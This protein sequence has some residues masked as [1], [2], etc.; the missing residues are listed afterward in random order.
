MTA[1]TT[2]I[3]NQSI[4]D[5]P[6]SG[7]FKAVLL[8]ILCQFGHRLPFSMRAVPRQQANDFVVKGNDVRGNYIGLRFSGNSDGNSFTE[9]RFTQN[10]HPIDVDGAGEN[11]RWAVGGVGNFWSGQEMF[12]LNG[13]GINDLPHQELDLFGPLRRDFP[14]VVEL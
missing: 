12:D 1:S 6:F 8:E 7:D 5:L 10:L 4:E 11:N 13:D 14:A 2:E 3:L 9:N